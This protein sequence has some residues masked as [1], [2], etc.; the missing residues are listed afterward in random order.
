M[1]LRRAEA[2]QHHTTPP[3]Q[4]ND[5]SSAFKLG[6]NPVTK[7]HHAHNVLRRYDLTDH[8]VFGQASL[9]FAGHTASHF[10]TSEYELEPRE[11]QGSLHISRATSWFRN[12]LLQKWVICWR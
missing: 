5:F 10:K 6:C 8:I 3:D 9:L 2:R 4:S 11:P 12:V 1:S 7:H